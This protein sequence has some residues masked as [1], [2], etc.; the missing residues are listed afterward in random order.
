MKKIAI[1]TC[2]G[3][4]TLSEKALFLLK[5]KGLANTSCS[6]KKLE[7]DDPRLIEVIEKLGEESSI[8]CGDIKIVKIPDDV[9]DWYIDEYDG[10]ETIKEGRC[11]SGS[12]S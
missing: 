5:E 8:P 10:M 7:R 3:G 12:S 2:Y 1:N 9:K 11:W 6:C 4:F